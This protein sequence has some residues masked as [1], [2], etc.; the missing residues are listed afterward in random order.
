[1]KIKVGV[2]YNSWKSLQEL[3][4]VDLPISVAFDISELIRQVLG[5]VLNV[6]KVRAELIKQHGTPVKEKVEKNGKTEEVETGSY[7]FDAVSQ[8]S[9]NVE[10]A[11]VTE[12]EIEIPIQPIKLSSIANEMT[13]KGVKLSLKPETLIP[14]D[15]L[16]VR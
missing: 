5:N 7:T 12:K 11:K 6:H 8:K 4:K 16:I 15:W 10:L 14:L 3:T 2:L 1:M 9:F 13:I